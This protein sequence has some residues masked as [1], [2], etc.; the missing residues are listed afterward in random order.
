MFRRTFQ[1]AS[2][3][4][5]LQCLPAWSQEVPILPAPD[6][7]SQLAQTVPIDRAHQRT[8]SALVNPR[9]SSSSA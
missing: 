9:P 7:M 2:A 4:V 6:S 8:L 5:L 3:A 1:V